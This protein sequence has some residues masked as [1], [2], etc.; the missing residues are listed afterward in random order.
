MMILNFE[1]IALHF[2]AVRQEKNFTVDALSEIVNCSPQHLSQVLLGKAPFSLKLLVN[3]CNALDVTPND[4]LLEHITSK[5]IEVHLSAGVQRI[6]SDCDSTEVRHML[7]ISNS[8]K[9][10]LRLKTDKQ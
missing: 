5:G 9:Q 3:L 10:S 6:Y 8:L 4:V 2:N 1:L 7:A